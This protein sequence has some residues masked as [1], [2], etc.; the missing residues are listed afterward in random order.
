MRTR[1]AAIYRQPAPE[2]RQKQ[3]ALARALPSLALHK[4]ERRR[5]R[6]GGVD[7][8]W[9][10]PAGTAPPPVLLYLHGGGYVIGSIATH[11][12]LVAM[13]ARNAGARAF[14]PE[15][16]LA[17]EHPFP[18]AL[19]DATAAFEGLLASGVPPRR[20]VVCGD[21][22]GGGLSL[23]LLVRLRDAGTPL[24]AGAVLISPWVDLS[25]GSPSYDRNVPYDFGDRELL[26]YWADLY[27]G[28]TPA[29]EPLLS[30]L[31]A[32]LKGL[33][34]LCVF[35]GGVELMIDEI[36]AL[37]DKARAAGVQVDFECAGDLAHNYLMLHM[38]AR[39]AVLAIER[40]AR[41][42]RHVCSA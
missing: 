29:T 21:S 16:R 26:L 1:L 40:A 23:S 14:L 12:D 31:Y 15:Y 11:G 38:M 27:R 3:D 22:A 41:F 9:L 33:P 4:V 10:V 42:V 20:I 18:A 37:C 6:I 17:P 30:P 28:G 8:T 24:P 25:C 34:P 35:A 2:V 13:L 39:P 7:G 32:D 19:D 5:E 36:R